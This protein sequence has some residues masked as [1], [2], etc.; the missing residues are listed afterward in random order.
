MIILDVYHTIKPYEYEKGGT[1]GGKR[2]PFINRR[3][4][5]KRKMHN[6]CTQLIV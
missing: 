4:K 2:E 5:K 3:T 1:G 6:N